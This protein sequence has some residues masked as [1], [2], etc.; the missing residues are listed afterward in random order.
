MKQ[1]IKQLFLLFALFALF[2]QGMTGGIKADESICVNDSGSSYGRIVKVHPTQNTIRF[3]E[4][5]NQ[6]DKKELYRAQLP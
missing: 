1:K 4:N 2:P 6:W 3:T 5:K